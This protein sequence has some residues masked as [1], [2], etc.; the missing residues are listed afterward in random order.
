VVELGLGNKEKAIAWLQRLAN[1][2]D[3]DS[4]LWLA[5]DHVFDPLH[6]D[7]KFQDIVRKVNLPS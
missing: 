3:D 7:P 5:T 2:H 6:T 1:E 4:L